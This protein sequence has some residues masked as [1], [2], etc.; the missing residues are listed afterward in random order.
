MSVPTGQRLTFLAATSNPAE[1]AHPD[2][3]TGR[4]A[5]AGGQAVAT[6]QPEQH[7]VA[8]TEPTAAMAGG[9]RR[10]AVARRRGRGVEGEAHWGA[11]ELQARPAWVGGGRS[12]E[13]ESGG[14][15][16]S[17]AGKEEGGGAA[18]EGW[19]S[20]SPWLPQLDQ[21]SRRGAAASSQGGSVGRSAVRGLRW[22]RG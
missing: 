11:A 8:G 14:W 9:W 13:R 1:S 3:E 15:R 4:H 2:Q 10:R 5:A 19:G 6:R 22:S 17:A 20:T 21:G 12:S 7:A 16:C 18:G